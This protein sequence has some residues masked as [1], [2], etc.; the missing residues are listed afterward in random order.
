MTPDTCIPIFSSGKSVAA[1]L[2]GCL[3]QEDK[4]Q[5]D[6]LVCSYWPEFT[7]GGKEN[8]KISDIMRHEGGLRKFHK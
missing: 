8:L 5:Y 4:L 1:I 2:M 7:N 3:R 6:S